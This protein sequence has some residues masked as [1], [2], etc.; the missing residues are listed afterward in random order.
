MATA[1]GIRRKCLRVKQL[2]L[3]DVSLI[4]LIKERYVDI[5]NI[6]RVDKL[7]YCREYLL[8]CLYFNISL[9]K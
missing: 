1:T 6:V 2:Y 9:L 5:P 3:C 4:Y 8:K 7:I